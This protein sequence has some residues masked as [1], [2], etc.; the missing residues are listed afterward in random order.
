MQVFPLPSQYTI[1]RILL[2]TLIGGFLSI[3]LGKIVFALFSLQPTAFMVQLIGLFFF[4]NFFLGFFIKNESSEISKVKI[5]GGIGSI[6][7]VI[8]GG[9]CFF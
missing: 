3:W 4:F 6:S 2:E 8:L 9:V 5:L 1:V 7:G